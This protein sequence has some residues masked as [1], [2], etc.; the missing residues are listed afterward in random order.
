MNKKC[1]ISHEFATGNNLPLKNS[2]KKE[3]KC[4]ETPAVPQEYHFCPQPTCLNRQTKGSQSI[5]PAFLRREHRDSNLL[6]LCGE[7]SFACVR[8]TA[9][10]TALAFVG[11]ALFFKVE[12]RQWT[13]KLKMNQS[14]KCEKGTHNE[15]ERNVTLYSDLSVETTSHDTYVYPYTWNLLDMHLLT[16]QQHRVDVLAST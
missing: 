4:S 6:H 12:R 7:T 9:T 11:L 13:Q 2:K 15:A 14:R 1:C 5:S 8:P 16:D 3:R 10:R